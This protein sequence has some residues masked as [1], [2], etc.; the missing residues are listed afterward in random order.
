M[1][2]ATFHSNRTYIHDIN[3]IYTPLYFIMDFSKDGM[4]L[5]NMSDHCNNIV[6]C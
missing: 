5:R 4:S 2:T 1:F 6:N 3:D